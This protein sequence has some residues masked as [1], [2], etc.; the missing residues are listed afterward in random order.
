MQLGISSYTY[1]WAI[2]VPGY[3][4][5]RSPM[6]AFDLLARAIGHGVSVLQVA[7]NLPLSG[8]PLAELDAFTEQA[9]AANVAIEVGTRGIEPE[10]LRAYLA[11]ARRFGSPF[12]RVVID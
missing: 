7:D 3:E 4:A 5:P 10:N 8:L 12:V 6:D 1:T 9:R 11:L 2:G